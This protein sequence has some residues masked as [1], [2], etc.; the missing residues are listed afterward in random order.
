MGNTKGLVLRRN[1]AQRNRRRGVTVKVV[2]AAPKLTSRAD[3]ILT[4]DKHRVVVST[5][6]DKCGLERV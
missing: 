4:R 1:G 2:C 6:V 5:T 3:S